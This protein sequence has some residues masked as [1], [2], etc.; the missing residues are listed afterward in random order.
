MVVA[1]PYTV[2]HSRLCLKATKYVLPNKVEEIVSGFLPSG[3]GLENITI[4]GS[5]SNALYSFVREEKK[6]IFFKL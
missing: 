6:I 4:I 3:V 5:S 1:R 2:C